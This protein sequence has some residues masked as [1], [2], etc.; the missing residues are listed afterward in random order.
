[1]RRTK[2]I[3]T[4]LYEELTAKGYHVSAHVIPTTLAKNLPHVHI[5]RTGGFTA[6]LVVE[7]HQVSFD[8]YAKNADEAMETACKLT[9][10]IRSLDNVHYAEV[11]TLPYHN[12]DPRH[13]T[14]P[15][16]TFNSQIITRP[17][18]D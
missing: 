4:K 6:D 11:V 1:M 10:D 17:Q 16:V 9:G 13:P 3:E 12:P 14:L 18:E 7:T 8:I 15:R 5:T 2:D